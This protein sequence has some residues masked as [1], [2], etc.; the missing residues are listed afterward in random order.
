ME[1]FR[2]LSLIVAL[3]KEIE[4]K[5]TFQD[6]V[7]RNPVMRDLFDVMPDIAASEAT[8][9]IQGESGTGKEL[10]ARA[11]HNLSPRKDGPLVVVNCGALPEHL[12]EA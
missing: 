4:E 10:F 1:T 3:R 5:Y 12:L 9:Q 11:I 8:V 6:L 2:D 7:S